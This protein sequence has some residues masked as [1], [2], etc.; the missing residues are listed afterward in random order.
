MKKDQSFEK[1]KGKK[2]KKY[3]KPSYT[4]H[5]KLGRMVVAMST[6]G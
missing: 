5:G 2:K 3:R 4:K 6:A 1:G